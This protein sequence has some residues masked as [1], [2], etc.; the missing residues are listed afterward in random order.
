M[1]KFLCSNGVIVF[2]AVVCLRLGQEGPVSLLRAKLR[3]L[4]GLAAVAVADQE[5]R[6]PWDTANL[7]TIIVDFGEFDSRIILIER[8][9]ILMSIGDFPESLSQ[10]MLVGCNVSRRIGRNE[11]EGT[12]KGEGYFKV[13]SD[14]FDCYF[15]VFVSNF[16]YIYIYI[17]MYVCIYIYIYI[18]VYTHKYVRTYVHTY[19]YIHTYICIYLSFPIFVFPRLPSSPGR[20]V[21]K[22]AKSALGIIILTLI[23]LAIIIIVS[24]VV[25]LY[26]Y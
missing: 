2:I 22:E 16:I 5:P 23:I 25:R 24:I 6:A 19:T 10:T 13:F 20:C 3:L 18:Y 26:Y 11:M 4:R 8:G 17:Y 9:G 21:R 7:R 14:C 15:D 12:N 1:S